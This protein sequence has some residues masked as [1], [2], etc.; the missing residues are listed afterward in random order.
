MIINR[1]VFLIG[2][3]CCGKS[4]LGAELARQLGVEFVDLDAA[5]ER[6]A[7]MSVS[8]FWREHGEAAFRRIE[9]EALRHEC[10]AG[11]RVVAC[12]GGT[13]CQKGNMELM[14]RHGITVWLTASADTL[15]QRL[16]M[17]EHNAKRPLVAGKSQNEI[18][19]IVAKGLEDRLPFYRQAAITH[20][21]TLIDTPE[22]VR[23]TAK[24]LK[25]KL[26]NNQ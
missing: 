6:A 14:N 2:Y 24:A 25:D 3:M 8:E 7:G 9:R 17:P 10:R 12:G 15:T 4:T 1:P 22:Q 20:D 13:P 23:A 16:C 19:A 21:A 11:A 26:N 18:E 5:V